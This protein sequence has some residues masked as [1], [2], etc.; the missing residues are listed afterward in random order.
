M[1]N[2]IL[3]AILCLSVIWFAPLPARAAWVDLPIRVRIISYEQSKQICC[4]ASGSNGWCWEMTPHLWVLGGV[5]FDDRNDP[6][7]LKAQNCM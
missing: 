2:L 3:A 6:V 1:K 4:F 7:P 5:V